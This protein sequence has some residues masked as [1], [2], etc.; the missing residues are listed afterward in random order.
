MKTM[1][2]RWLQYC[3]MQKNRSHKFVQSCF[4][5]TSVYLFIFSHVICRIKGLWF[6]DGKALPLSKSQAAVVSVFWYWLMLKRFR[7][8]TLQSHKHSETS[9]KRLRNVSLRS[10][11]MLYCPAGSKQ[12]SHMGRIC[13]N[14][15]TFY[16]SCTYG[17]YQSVSVWFMWGTVFMVLER[18]RGR[19][20][21]R[22]AEDHWRKDLQ[23]QHI[24]AGFI[25]NFAPRAQRTG[26]GESHFPHLFT[27]DLHRQWRFSLCT[28]GDAEAR[29]A[30]WNLDGHGEERDS[31]T[32]NAGQTALYGHMMLWDLP[33]QEVDNVPAKSILLQVRAG[34]RSRGETALL[35][36]SQQTDY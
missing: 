29:Q 16:D 12:V 35:Q 22:G 19:E 10:F 26:F 6:V 11:A 24:T 4:R 30:A 34:V 28:G 1:P 15:L 27:D 20:Q 32:L 18:E 21:A 7:K 36:M 23:S 33:Q 14:V 2:H 9:Q 13:H 8:D 3:T 31:F 17:K 5:E 25:A